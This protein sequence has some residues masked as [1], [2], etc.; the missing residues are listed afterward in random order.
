MLPRRHPSGGRQR[1][2]EG[3]S[4]L[5]GLP[6]LLPAGRWPA[7]SVLGAVEEGVRQGP[8]S[9][10]LHS[11]GRSGLVVFDRA[12]VC[13]GAA[14]FFLFG[15]GPTSDLQVRTGRKTETF[16]TSGVYEQLSEDCA[17]SIIYGETFDSLDLVA[18]SA[19]VANIWVTGLR[20]VHTGRGC[21]GEQKNGQSR[22]SQGHAES[23]QK[24]LIFHAYQP[25]CKFFLSEICQRGL[26]LVS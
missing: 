13:F 18:N 12:A 8:H 9:P 21:W 2:E 14:L 20:L 19:E 23:V 17:F 25:L 5:Q 15:C 24:K 10:G 7:G 22:M 6:A 1:A 4:R 16:R 3:A 26:V 11:R